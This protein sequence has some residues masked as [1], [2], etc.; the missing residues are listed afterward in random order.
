MTK[1]ILII[2]GPAGSGKSTQNELL[3]KKL[4]YKS[5]VMSDI[6][7]EEIKKKTKVGKYIH[8]LISKGN[9]APDE[10][11]C[12]VLFKKIQKERSNKIILDGFPRVTTQ[13]IIF[14][15][16]LHTKN[17]KLKKVL[18]INVPKK[19]CVKRMLLRKRDDDT[20]EII[21]HR[22]NIYFKDTKPVLDYYKKTGLLLDINGKQTIEEVH[23]EILKKIKNV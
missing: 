22:F 15:Y 3:S 10:I 12:D 13:A 14:N 4:K 6:L 23:K 8:K 17:Y 16:F 19:E 9:L 5:I 1:E 11:A 20:K 7:K 21:E 2:L 18:F